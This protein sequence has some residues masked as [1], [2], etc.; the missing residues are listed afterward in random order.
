MRRRG[1]G[2]SWRCPDGSGPGPSTHALRRGALRAVLARR[3]SL[4]RAVTTAAMLPP[5]RGRDTHL[6]A[7][8]RLGAM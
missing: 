5:G 6:A 1:R 7:R 3:R 4:L 2:G 8:S